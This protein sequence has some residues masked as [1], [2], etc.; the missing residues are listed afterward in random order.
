M[1]LTW[2]FILF[3]YIL[4]TIYA[5]KVNVFLVKLIQMIDH[6]IKETVY[7]RRSK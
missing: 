6:S 4:E 1:S 3:Q 7:F 5:F 2:L